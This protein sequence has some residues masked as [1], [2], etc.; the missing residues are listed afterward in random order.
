MCEGIYIDKI[1]ILLVW[2]FPII[3][4]IHDFEEIIVVEKWIAKNKPD[5]VHKLPKR[6][7][8]FFEKH[9]AMKT[10]QFSIVVFVEFIITKDLCR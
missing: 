1:T 4:A 7:K 9:F 10:D 5:F 3:F 8:S 6:A 2:L